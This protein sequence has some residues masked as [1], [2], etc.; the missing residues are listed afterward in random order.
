MSMFLR[1][2]LFFWLSALLI[3]ASFFL[4]GQLSGSEVIE[5]KREMLN[6]QAITVSTLLQQGDHR[7]IHRWLQ[8]L[9]PRERPL[10]ID[11]DGNIPFAKRMNRMRGLVHQLRFPLEE[12]IQ[13]HHMGLV[14]LIVA[15]PDS[16]PALFLVAPLE[17]GQMQRIPVWLRFL[18]ALIIIGLI[19]Y[20][21]A[22]L[23]SRRIRKLRT[24]VQGFSEGDLSRRVSVDGNDEVTALAADFNL[25]ADR[26]N[27]MLAS[28]RQLVSDVSHELR[29]PLA[30]LRIALELA[31]RS[32]NSAEVLHR[33]E[34]ETDELETLVTELLSLARIESGQFHLEKQ[35][36][37]LAGLLRQVVHD[38][39]FEGEQKGCS[40][41]LHAVEAIT[42]EVDPVLI[43]SAVEN[44]IRNAIRYSGEQG[45]IEVSTRLD[46]DSFQIIIEDSGPGVPESELDNLFQPFAR[47]AEARDRVSGGFGLGLA[48]T[49]RSLLAH[50]GHARAENRS[51]GGLRVILS[52]PLESGKNN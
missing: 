4:L 52:L 23:L 26:V 7:L 34:K 6:T 2:F 5:R 27:D 15:V 24:A 19:S 31:Q 51:E 42:L 40:V 8:Q 36:T 16:D 22:L 10:L 32:S 18:S 14:S 1:I 25:M 20:L 44:V 12:G 35:S 48:I 28:Q 21:L 38:A 41:N 49:G 46:T 3:A 9:P 43:R 13:H 50:H 29:S 30:R 17:P 11:R 37:D 39:N 33:I 45:S 47:V